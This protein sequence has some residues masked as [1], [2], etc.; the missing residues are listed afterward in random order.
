[1]LPAL[2]YELV[3]QS[4]WL[5]TEEFIYGVALGQGTPGPVILGL[6]LVGVKWGGLFG[7]MLVSAALTLPGLIW[8]GF[9]GWVQQRFQNSVWFV[10]VLSGIRPA[11]PGLLAA[12]A[13]NF[14][15]R[16]GPPLHETLGVSS[17]VFLLSSIRVNPALIILGTLFLGYFI[18]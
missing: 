9:M 16:G 3:E 10:R 1:M 13:W 17:V 4:R 2:A 5:S 6:S 11:I 18:G 8:M 7:G 15:V 14:M 12:L